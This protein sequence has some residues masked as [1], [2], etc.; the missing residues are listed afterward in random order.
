MDPHFEGVIFQTHAAELAKRL[1]HEFPAYCALDVRSPADYG[2]GHIASARNTTPGELE[3]GLPPGTDASTEFF[4]IGAG[5]GDPAIRA[6]SR[7]LRRHGAHRV[8]EFGGGMNEWSAYRFPVET[9]ASAPPESAPA[10]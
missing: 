9:G 10:H 3:A 2:A 5:P 8:V 1:G 4:V 6:A 7:A